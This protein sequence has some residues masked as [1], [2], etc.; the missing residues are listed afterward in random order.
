ML[1]S[2]TKFKSYS[3]SSIKN[4][5]SFKKINAVLSFLHKFKMAT[6]NGGKT[7]FW[8]KL[9]VDSADTLG[10]KNFVEITLSW[11]ISKINAFYADIQDDL[12][13]WQEND[14]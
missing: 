11:T 7:I 6:K 13:K 3:C 9:P 2:K 12:Q 14:F 10:V 5:N 4:V 1:L 8:E